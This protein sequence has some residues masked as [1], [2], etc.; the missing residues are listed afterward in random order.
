MKKLI[1]LALTLLMVSAMAADI[2]GGVKFRIR[3][4]LD[5]MNS[6][7][8]DSQYMFTQTDIRVRPWFDYKVNDMLMVKTA[9]EIGDVKFG[10]KKSGADVGTDEKVVEVKHAYLDVKP[11]KD[12]NIRMGL[13]AYAD[14]NGLIFDDDLAGMRWD[15]SFDQ[16]MA[17]FGIYVPVEGGEEYEPKVDD[18]FNYGD[19]YAI[20]DLGFK[21]DDNMK[22]GLTNHILMSDTRTAIDDDPTTLDEY[23]AQNTTM[24]ISPWFMGKFADMVTVNAQF[25][26]NM[27]SFDGEKIDVEAPDMDDEAGMAFSLK[28]DAQATKELNVG[29]NVL[30]LGSDEDGADVYEPYS[31]FYEN[32]L[33]IMT[34]GGFNDSKVY[35]VFYD[36]DPD[37]ETLNTGANGL[38]LPVV[39]ANYKAMKDLKLGVALGYGMTLED[40]TYMDG[41]NEETSTS[42]GFEVDFTAEYKMFDGFKWMPYVAIY[43]PGEAQTLNAD[44]TDMQYKIGW[45]GKVA[46][47]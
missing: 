36:S 30:Y 6:Y 31:G 20:I 14:P 41:T 13:Q 33:Q 21:V 24:W 42:L 32:G 45:V 22:L 23:V 39:Y 15:G 26:Y 47:K 8:S 38:I 29:L 46:L 1:A 7:N 12:H 44:N 35:N 2:K 25:V 11:T 17:G 5:T 10:D 9:F 34:S 40:V 37:E 4:G 18:S 27:R 16:F 28:V 19:V 3:Q 43:M